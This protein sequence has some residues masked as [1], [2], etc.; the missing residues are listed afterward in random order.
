MFMYASDELAF[1]SFQQALSHADGGGH[2]FV[3]ERDLL[4]ASCRALA[5]PDED[6]VAALDALVGAELV[7]NIAKR[8][9]AVHFDGGVLEVG[10]MEE[11]EGLGPEVV[12]G[13]GITGAFAGRVFAGTT[14]AVGWRRGPG[15]SLAGEREDVVGADAVRGARVEA[16]AEAVGAGRGACACGRDRRAWSAWRAWSEKTILDDAGE[17]GELRGRGHGLVAVEVWL[18]GGAR[19]GGYGCGAGGCGC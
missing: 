16:P 13:I 9:I 11:A 19:G 10:G 7:E 14:G 12:A 3:G 18:E 17:R 8:L 2:G 4:D 5:D 15:L 1:N 6:D